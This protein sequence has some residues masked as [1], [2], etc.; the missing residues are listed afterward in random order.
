VSTALRSPTYRGAPPWTRRPRAASTAYDEH[1]QPRYSRGITR[2]GG[3]LDDA[4][5]RRGDARHA[6]LE[7]RLQQLRADP[8]P[9][10][11]A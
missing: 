2:R 10:W 9:G 7:Q 8:P 6:L 3:P 4:I 1:E 11:P 5:A